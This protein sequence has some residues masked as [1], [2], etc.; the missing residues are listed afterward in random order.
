MIVSNQS[1][2]SNPLACLALI[3]QN[4]ADRTITV[5]LTIGSQDPIIA[6][7]LVLAQNQQL[8]NQLP[9]N[10]ATQITFFAG[11]EYAEQ[12]RLK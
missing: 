7:A 1:L 3:H 8:L 4:L 11:I 9:L 5:T 2:A 10:I 6:S 12:V